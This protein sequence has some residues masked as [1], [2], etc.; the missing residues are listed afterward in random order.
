MFASYE[1]FD[2]IQNEVTPNQKKKLPPLN[3]NQGKTIEPILVHSGVI[4]TILQLV[5]GMYHDECPEV[6]AAFQIF[7]AETIKSVIRIEK[8]QQLMS[9]VEFM[10][11]ILG[12]CRLALEDEA[13]LLHSPFQVILAS[14]WHCTVD[15]GL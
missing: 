3:L 8:N 1:S 13:H 15:T 6:S 7:A 4:V 11:V 5:P 12:S 10:S 2:P 14:D 9:D